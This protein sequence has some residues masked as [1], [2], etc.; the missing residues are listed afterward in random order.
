MKSVVLLL[1]S[2]L[3]VNCAHKGQKD[4]SMEL[5]PSWSTMKK[6]KATD[7]ADNESDIAGL[8]EEMNKNVQEWI[9]Y[10][11]TNGRQHMQRYLSRSSK[12]LEEM[13]GILR[14]HGLPGDLV[15]VAL[16]ESGFNAKAH[17]HASAVG[18]WQFIRSTAKSYD[19]EVSYY[20]DERRDFVKS[21]Q[22][23][24]K[25]LKALYNLFGS[26]YLAI[27]SYNAGEN[28]IKR[29]V[30]KHYTRNFWDLVEKGVLPKETTN[31]VP[32]FLAARLIAKHP[33]KYGFVDVPYEAPL[34]YIEIPSSKSVSLKTLA[35]QLGLNYTEIQSLN[36]AY[37][38]GIIPVKKGGPAMVRVPSTL[39]RDRVV[40]AIERSSQKVVLNRAYAAVDKEHEKYKIRNGDTLSTI[41][42]RFKVSLSSL[43]RENGLSRRSVIRAGKVLRIPAPRKG[44]RY[45]KK[46]HRRT[47][48]VKR[49]ETLLHIANKYKVRMSKIIRANKLRSQQKILVGKKLVIPR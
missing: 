20:V 3:L 34:D 45:R 8:P 7:L 17:S 11:Q 37:K 38:R 2:L 22:A 19:L 24:S 10:F 25:Y 47:H 36:P 6:V 42:E 44:T 23:A 26:W 16:I 9:S 46:N 40:A 30:M 39:A 15:Y 21:T 13:K 4:G 43:L 5:S 41:A 31:Y 33:E 18:Y 35:Q 49:G 29:L 1:V 48:T 27:A 32:K 28:K 12:Y 14:S